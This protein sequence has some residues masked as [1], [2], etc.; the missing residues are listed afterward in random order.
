MA[1]LEK[2]FNQLDDTKSRHKIDV[3]EV[4][5]AIAKALAPIYADRG[6]IK[7]DLEALESSSEYGSDQYGE[8]YIWVRM[9]SDIDERERPFFSDWLQE[10]HCVHVDWD[11]GAMYSYCGECIVINDDGDVFDASKCIVEASEYKARLLN[12]DLY[13]S[14]ALNEDDDDARRNALIEAYMERTGCFPNVLSHDR[15]GNIFPVDTRKK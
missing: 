9:E 3:N 11:N 15:H 10:N 5:E 12:Q 14:E 13:E 2:L 4:N 7:R 6:D 8:I 1:S